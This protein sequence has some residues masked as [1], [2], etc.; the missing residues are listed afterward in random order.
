MRSGSKSLRFNAYITLLNQAGAHGKEN[1]VLA[2]HSS[3]NL[4]MNTYAPRPTANSMKS[5]KLLT[6]ACTKSVQRP[7]AAQNEKAQPPLIQ[8]VALLLIWLRRYD[9][10]LIQ[11]FRRSTHNP[12]RSVHLQTTIRAHLS[13]KSVPCAFPPGRIRLGGTGSGHV[14]YGPG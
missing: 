13:T 4:T 11:R 2:R 6:K 8:E 12:G 10:N 9:S 5:S 14:C 1:Q 7:V 3:P